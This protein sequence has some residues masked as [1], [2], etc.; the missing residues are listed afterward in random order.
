MRYQCLPLDNL[1][2]F[3]TALLTTVIIGAG[4]AIVAGVVIYRRLKDADLSAIF[5]GCQHHK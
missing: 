2:L 4:A 3:L 5:A 1:I